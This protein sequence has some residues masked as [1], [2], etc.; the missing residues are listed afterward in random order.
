MTIEMILNLSRRLSIRRRL[1]CSASHAW[2]LV[3]YHRLGLKGGNIID[4]AGR[5]GEFHLI[6]NL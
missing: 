4:W 5:E 6:Y 2:D 1:S 3:S